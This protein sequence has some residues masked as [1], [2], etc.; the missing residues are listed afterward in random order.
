MTLVAIYQTVPEDVL[1]MFAEKDSTKAAW[2][3]Q[4]TMHMGVEWIK[5]AK[6]Q[7]LMGDFKAICMKDSTLP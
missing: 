4:Q 3:T 2:E 7:I 1:L 5:E 6:V